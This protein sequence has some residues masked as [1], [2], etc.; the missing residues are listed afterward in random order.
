VLKPFSRVDNEVYM[1]GANLHIANGAGGTQTTNGLGNLIIGYKENDFNFPRTGSHNLVVGIDHGWES[2][3]GVVSGAGNHI[4]GAYASV[5]G[6]WR[7][8]ASA[9]AASVVGGRGNAA[10][11][12]RS[13]V[14]G[15]D[16][17][18]A[19]GYVASVIGGESNTASAPAAAVSG[20]AK[21]TQSNADGWSAGGYFFPDGGIGVFHSP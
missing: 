14:I 10:V 21:I 6:G 9:F 12:D 1:V 7:C 20:G 19:S 8:S 13:V 15:G 3:G 2:F 18:I 17:N 11:G 16:G 5:I 4:S